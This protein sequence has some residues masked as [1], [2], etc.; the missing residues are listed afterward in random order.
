MKS[1]SLILSMFSLSLLVLSC[2][3]T[4]S[5]VDDNVYM[6]RTAAVPVGA[7]LTDETSYSTFK[8]RKETYN[9]TNGYYTPNTISID[10]RANNNSLFGGWGAPFFTAGMYQGNF[11]PYWG[12]H[13]D[14][15]YLGSAYAFMYNPYFYSGYGGMNYGL[16]NTYGMNYGMNSFY[17]H[18]YGNNGMY[19][20]GGY[21][22][23]GNNAMYNNG[24]NGYG[25]AYCPSI[26]Y[27]NAS[28]IR[29]ANYVSGPR[30]TAGGGYYSGNDRGG[31]IQVKSVASNSNYTV[32]HSNRRVYENPAGNT[33][34]VSRER[35]APTYSRNSDQ[36]TR[37]P[38]VKVN[39]GIRIY[40]SGN[41]R[42]TS[43][44]SVRNEGMR[45]T[46]IVNSGVSRESSGGSR[47]GTSGSGGSVGRSSGGSTGARPG[48]RGN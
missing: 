20:A 32:D 10:P 19:S 36:S 28:P 15:F 8:H 6:M 31:S 24:F 2:N 12:M 26:N 44:P 27:A 14:G 48:G 47:E 43:Y 29:Q 16:F 46:S 45:N 3:S 1:K 30:S 40:E 5:L 38:H 11:N 9:P 34:V 25:N 35:S 23:N 37:E 4:Q 41:S 42:T 21:W 22:F 17:N 18:M 39:S 7:D 33:S 13:R